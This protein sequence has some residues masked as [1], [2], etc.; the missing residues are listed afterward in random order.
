ME[1][2]KMNESLAVK[3]IGIGPTFDSDRLLQEIGV[4]T[5]LNHPCIVRIIGYT[6]PNAECRE[7]RIATEV[8]RKGSLENVLNRVKRGEIPDFW[9]HTNITKMM[10]GVVLGMKYLHSRGIIHRDLKPGNILLDEKGQIRIA[11]FG[12]AKFEDYGATTTD[13][14]GTLAYMASEALE[15]GHATKKSDVFAF[16]LIL[17]EVLVG[18]SVFPKKGNPL[19]IALMHAEGTRPEIPEVIHS[20]IANLIR[21]CWSKN[22]E[23][24]PTFEEVFE[25]LDANQFRFFED[26]EYS[27]CER[28]IC[29]VMAEELRR[30]GWT[31]IE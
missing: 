4:L 2:R 1:N 8:M 15:G 11:D 16:G 6:L 7:A 10:I 27:E 25:I 30:R 29:E 17:Y 19:Q 12:T 5:A 18:E 22:P 24:R 23:D 20:S 31:G 14:I 21:K 3:Y 13:L 9:S 26:V 28:F